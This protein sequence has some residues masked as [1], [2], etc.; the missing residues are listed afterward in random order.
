MSVHH[1]CSACGHRTG[2]EQVR[3]DLYL[4]QRAIGD[5]QALKRGRLGRRLVRRSVTRSLMRALWR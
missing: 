3:R 2:L 1:V 5:Y 4:S